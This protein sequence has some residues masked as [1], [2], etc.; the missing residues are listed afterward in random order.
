MQRDTH[1]VAD[2]E[3]TDTTAGLHPQALAIGSSDLEQDLEPEKR[4]S[5]TAQPSSPAGRSGA[6]T[7]AR[8]SGRRSTSA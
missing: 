4:R 8:C 1:V 3:M 6:S 2:A 5:M 7:M